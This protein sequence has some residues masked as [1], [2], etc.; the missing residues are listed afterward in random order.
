MYPDI[1]KPIQKILYPVDLNIFVVDTH[2]NGDF[3]PDVS[4]GYQK[5]KDDRLPYFLW[6]FIEFKLP[7][8]NISTSEQ[9]GQVLDYFYK[10]HEKQPHRRDFVAILSNFVAAWVFTARF[11][12]EEVTIST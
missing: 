1:I 12:A 3:H 4:V 10:V 9:C 7:T 2:N 5:L 11:E 6:Y 8:V